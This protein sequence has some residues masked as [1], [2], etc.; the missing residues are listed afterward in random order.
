MSILFY[1][2]FSFMQNLEQVGMALQVFHSLGQLG[3]ML[4]S[5][6]IG[7]QDQDMVLHEIQNAID[8]VTLVQGHAIMPEWH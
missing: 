8:P 1:C 5:V 4:V 2:T 3:S 6:L 7:Y